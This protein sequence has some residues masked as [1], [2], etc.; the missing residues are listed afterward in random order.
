MHTSRSKKA[1]ASDTLHPSSFCNH[2]YE[3]V[4]GHNEAKG[5]GLQKTCCAA[6]WRAIS[7]VR[8]GKARILKSERIVRDVV[9]GEKPSLGSCETLKSK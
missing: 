7:F 2:S 4:E 9:R 5:D 3:V 8:R 6:V 1:I